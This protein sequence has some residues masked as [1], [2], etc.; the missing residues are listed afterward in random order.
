MFQVT[1][2]VWFS[3][4]PWV[5]LQLFCQDRHQGDFSSLLP[6]DGIQISFEIESGKNP[7]SLTFNNNNCVSKKVSMIH[8]VQ[9]QPDHSIVAQDN[10]KPNQKTEEGNISNIPIVLSQNSGRNRRYSSTRK[11]RRCWS[12]E[13]HNRFINALQCLGGPKGIHMYDI[14]AHTYNKT[15]TYVIPIVYN[16]VIHKLPNHHSNM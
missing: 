15:Y 12:P 14:H 7:Q 13:L 11:R 4:C 9:D 6:K 5:I 2:W 10:H 1:I 16:I 8:D 3:R